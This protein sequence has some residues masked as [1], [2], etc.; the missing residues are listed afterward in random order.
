[1][2]SWAPSP[3]LFDDPKEARGG[4]V[5]RRTGRSTAGT[6][7][8]VVVGI[9]EGAFTATVLTDSVPSYYQPSAPVP[10]TVPTSNEVRIALSLPIGDNHSALYLGYGDSIT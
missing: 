3:H 7:Q 8:A 5:P 6:G 10:V 9:Q 2:F 1:M 4:L